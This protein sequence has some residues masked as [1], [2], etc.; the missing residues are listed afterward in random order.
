[1][2]AHLCQCTDAGAYAHKCPQRTGADA[3]VDK[4]TG[5]DSNPWLDTEADAD[6]D[7]GAGT[8]ISSD[9]YRTEMRA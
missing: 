8:D 2:Q 5:A 1:M 4:H 7:A 3:G 9:R 6:I